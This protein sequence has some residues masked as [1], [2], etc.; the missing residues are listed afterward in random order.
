MT[1]NEPGGQG[2]EVNK[3][4]GIEIMTV[5]EAERRGRPYMEAIVSERNDFKRRYRESLQD[6]AE[7]LGEV[8]KLREL[9]QQVAEI[10]ALLLARTGPNPTQLQIEWAQ[11]EVRSEL[12]K[13]AHGARAFTRHHR[14]PPF[15][16]GGAMLA[17][18]KVNEAD[19]NPWVIIF[20]A[21][22]KLNE[23][24]EATPDGVKCCAEQNLMYRITEPTNPGET[25]IYRVLSIA[26]VGEPRADDVSGMLHGT[27]TPCAECR[28]RL[29]YDPKLTGKA[30]IISLQTEIVTQSADDVDLNRV[31]EVE[32]LHGMHGE[33]R[34]DD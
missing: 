25:G 5:A 12:L 11:N 26:V 14:V 23:Q 32:H 2:H 29:V 6:R 13:L 22:T 10:R 4:K 19:G 3:E 20:D 18:R 15:R 30:G 24:H 27:L 16:V 1:D 31:D 17:L 8:E 28:D 9:E 33:K 7:K 34:E 21:N